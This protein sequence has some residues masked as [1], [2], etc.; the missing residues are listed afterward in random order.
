MQRRLFIQA[1]V[2]ASLAMPLLAVAAA[3]VIEVFKTES[4][5]C[6]GAWVEHLKANGF[7][8]RVV[9][10]DNPSD[11]RQRGGIPDSLGSCHT[12]MVRGYAIEGHVP[13]SD[14]KRLLAMK[15]KAR[16]LAVP[17]MPLGSPGME[18][19]RKDPF[20]VLLVDAEGRTSV[21]KHYN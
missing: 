4:C 12:G 7:A 18:G 13:A 2:G 10:V 16:G 19:P 5:G 9:N 1:A 15:P 11:Y 8:T 20:D 14:I 21:F 3:P 6:C 17:G